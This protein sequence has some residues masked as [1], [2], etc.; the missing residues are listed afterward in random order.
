MGGGIV[1]PAGFTCIVDPDPIDD[2]LLSELKAYW[3]LKRGARAMPR[4]ADIDP[5]DLRKHLGNLVMIEVLA[6]QDDFR[7]RLIGTHVAAQHGRDSTGKTVRELYAATDRVIFD[8]S[9]TVLRNV[10]AHRRPVRASNRLRM[11]DRDYTTSDQLHLP[12]SEDGEAVSMILCE[13]RFAAASRL[14]ADRNE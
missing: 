13:S 5:L 1:W 2:P 3:D 4:R 7:Y 6:G 12:L 11:V 10:V 14:A 9:M 8:W